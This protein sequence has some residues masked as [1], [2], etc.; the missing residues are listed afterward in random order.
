MSRAYL[1]AFA[2]EQRRKRVLINKRRVMR[3][4]CDPLALPRN[5]R[6]SYQRGV[7]AS[8]LLNMSQSTLSICL[9][10]VT[11]AL[12]SREVLLKYIKFP[13]QRQERETVMAE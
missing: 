10:E 12:N 6:G 1:L 2:E 13:S 9:E 7:G 8:F 11:N 3:D 5:D 4:S